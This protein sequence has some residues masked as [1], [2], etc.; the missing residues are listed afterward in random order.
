MYSSFK[1]FLDRLGSGGQTI[2]FSRE[3]RK[4]AIALLYYRVIVVDGRVRH[5]ELHR[6]RQI[7]SENLMIMEE[8]LLQFEDDVIQRLSSDDST[9][10]LLDTVKKLPLP[11]RV[12][13]LANMH[14]ISISDR[15]LHEFEINLVYRAAEL[16]D[17]GDENLPAV[18]VRKGSSWTGRN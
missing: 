1:A 12:E 6:F 2:E 4:L 3:D 10:P 7:L 11:D 13:I 14:E 18:L 8:E 17:I 15:E 9:F 5:E 16:L